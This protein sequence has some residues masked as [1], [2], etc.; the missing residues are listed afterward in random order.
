MQIA[1]TFEVLTAGGIRRTLGLLLMLSAM[2]AA[3]AQNNPGDLVDPADTS[4]AID[5]AEVPLY[6][7]LFREAGL[8]IQ[9]AGLKERFQQEFTSLKAT[10]DQS[11]SGNNVGC[12]LKVEMYTTPEG[13]I[14]I[15]S[16]QLIGFEG[17]GANPIDALAQSHMIP[18]VRTDGTLPAPYENQSYYV[19]IKREQGALKAG[20]IPRELR[21]TLERNAK[22]EIARRV[23]MNEVQGALT[24]AKVATIDKDKYW[25]DVAQQT[26]AVVHSDA[27]RQKVQTLV[28]NF[29]AEERQFNEAYQQF[30]QT[31]QE[32]RDQ[33]QQMQTLETISR[34]TGLVS[35]AIQLG[36][37][38]SSGETKPVSAPSDGSQ[39][40]TRVMIEYHQRN[41]DLESGKVQEWA[42]KME[43]SGA[44]LQQI[45][46][47]LVT[48]VQSDGINIPDAQ[49]KLTL[50][51]KP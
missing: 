47:Q 16:G 50:P 26:L 18:G 13:A 25:S 33:Q 45:N 22:D 49:K 30:M 29:A 19:W 5:L 34:L 14:D 31:E 4:S 42:G 38:S 10:I 24:S 21:E 48:T 44:T 28:Q 8:M 46:D 23:R 2:A 51:G 35:S 1:K 32:L 37:L 3:S 9:D 43:V 27:E 7:D 6:I 40:A 20:I 17:T 39:E 36:E 41:I 12:L 15:P 11:V